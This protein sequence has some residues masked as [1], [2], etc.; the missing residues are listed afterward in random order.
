[1]SGRGRVLVMHPLLD[2]APEV[3]AASAETAAYPEGAPLT[4]EGIRAAA[5]GCRGIV[6]QLMDPIG[7][8][9]LSTPGLRV[10]G[11]VAVGHDNIDVGAATRHG[12]V[13]TNT[14]G[15]LDETTADLAFALL[16]AAARRV[17]EGDRQ[18]RDGRWKGWAVGHLLGQDV[19]G[20]V[21]GVV[22]MGRIGRALARRGRAFGMRVLYTSRNR[23]PA[24]QERD[25]DVTWRRLSEL[26]R[27]ADFVS[28]HVPLTPETGHLI[29]PAE[30]ALMKPSAVLVNTARGPIVDEAALV[31]A[32]RERRIFGAALDVYEDEPRLHPGLAELE[33]VVLAPHVGSASVRT[34]ARMCEVAARNV[35]AVL[36]GRRPP[37]PVNLD[38]LPEVL[39]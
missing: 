10:V 7:D 19:H 2:P 37:N 18:V 11:N 9:V 31:E 39:D 35:V 33:N 27:E 17:V 32:L 5:E 26:L 23:L 6:S 38:V 3:L 36:S 22:G 4:E 29:G 28:L 25:L 34:R 20:A 24:D 13:V 1:M 15:I 12:V 14:P 21:L 8:L 30:L 16:M